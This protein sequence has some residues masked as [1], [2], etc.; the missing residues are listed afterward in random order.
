LETALYA[1]ARLLNV[2]PKQRVELADAVSFFDTPEVNLDQTLERAWQT[3]PELRQ[4]LAQQHRAQLELR[5]AADA[6]LPK[7]S[8]TGFWAEQGLNSSN[9]IDR[10]STRLN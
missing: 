2:D 9:A 3:R 5:A 8:V 10:K 6:R 4:I 7:V 1:L